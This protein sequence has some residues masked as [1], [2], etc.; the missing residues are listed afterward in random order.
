MPRQSQVGD[1]FFADFETGTTSI[2]AN[3]VAFDALPE[4]RIHRNDTTFI[5]GTQIDTGNIVTNGNKIYS[6]GNL[7]LD[8]ITKHDIR[9]DVSER[10]VR[11]SR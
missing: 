9:S 8:A 4:I 1:S 3:T 11:Y 5:D 7:V 6:T 2:H 10:Y